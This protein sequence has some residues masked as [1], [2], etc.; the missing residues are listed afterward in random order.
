MPCVWALAERV[1]RVMR[2][3]QVRVDIFVTS[4]KPH[5]CVANEISISS[6]DQI[7]KAKK[8]IAR[9]WAEPYYQGWAWT[10]HKQMSDLPPVYRM[11][12]TPRELGADTLGREELHSVRQGLID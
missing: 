12:D 11:T 1:A 3:D 9:L 4:G 5:D 8:Y 7:G 2:A 6:G 10:D